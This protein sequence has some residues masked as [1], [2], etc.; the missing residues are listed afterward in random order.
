M[1]LEGL[2]LSEYKEKMGPVFPRARYAFQYLAGSS[3]YF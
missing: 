3:G 2:I 1:T